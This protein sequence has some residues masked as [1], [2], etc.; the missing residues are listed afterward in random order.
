MVVITTINKPT[1]QG[2]YRP[3]NFG[4]TRVAGAEGYRKIIAGSNDT[5]NIRARQSRSGSLAG[6]PA[7]CHQ[8]P[9]LIAPAPPRFTFLWGTRPPRA[10]V[11]RAAAKTFIGS[12]AFPARH[13]PPSLPPSRG[14]RP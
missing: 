12:D 3:K 11:R 2:C 8:I 1:R 4:E 13:P 5:S 9:P 7:S 14:T 10:Q 6:G